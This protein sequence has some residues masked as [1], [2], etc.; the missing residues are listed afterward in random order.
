METRFR[1]GYHTQMER[2][3]DDVKNVVRDSEEWLRSGVETVK[4]QARTAVEKADQAM[5]ERPYETLG[6]AFGVGLL[7]GVLAAGWLSAG[8]REELECEC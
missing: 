8:Q 2:V 1:N 6:V 4:Q 7:F 5:R 3:C